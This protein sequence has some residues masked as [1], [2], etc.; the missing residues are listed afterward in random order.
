MDFAGVN[1]EN[2]GYSAKVIVSTDNGKTWSERGSVNVPKDVRSYDEHM[3]VEKKDGT[4]W[5]LS[6]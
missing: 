3:V 5:M 4:L 1:M 2:D 6:Y